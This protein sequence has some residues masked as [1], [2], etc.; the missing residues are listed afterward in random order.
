MSDDV[1][2]HH[3]YCLYFTW[4][5]SGLERASSMDLAMFRLPLNSDQSQPGFADGAEDGLSG[6]PK[7]HT[8][9]HNS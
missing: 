7:D 8:I 3:A 4:I 2:D 6:H 1:A 9:T 5:I